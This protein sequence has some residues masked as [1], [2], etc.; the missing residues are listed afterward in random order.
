MQRYLLPARLVTSNKKEP[1]R[2][3][4]GWAS[5]GDG[6]EIA[7]EDI[8][9]RS[10]PCNTIQPVAWLIVRALRVYFQLRETIGC[11]KGPALPMVLL[12]SNNFLYCWR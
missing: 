10:F 1:L 6:L 11:V 5:A 4:D 8:L 2:S 9:T 3:A 12:L 7:N